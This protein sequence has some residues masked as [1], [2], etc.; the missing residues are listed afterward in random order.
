MLD[1][2]FDWRSDFNT[3]IESI[4]TH[5]KQFFKIARDIEQ[6]LQKKCIGIKDKQLL[7]II[8]DLR[9]FTGYHFYEEERLMEEIN[10]PD[11]E[12][13]KKRHNSFASKIAKISM[14]K[15]KETPEVELKKIWDIMQD[16][17]FNHILIDDMKM[18]EYILINE[19]STVIESEVKSP[20]NDEYEALYGTKICDL[21]VTK[22]YLFHEQSHKGRVV[23]VCKDKI[24]DMG[25]LS[26]LE[27]NI[28]F[29]DIARVSKAIQKLYSPQAFN[30]ASYGD[31]DSQLHFHIVPKYKDQ[32]E[33]GD[34]FSLD[35]KQKKLSQVEYE[36]MAKEI[37]KEIK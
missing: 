37:K 32:F 23:L 18:A 30:Y 6:Q 24:K 17:F 5:H 13:H 27:R 26:V 35:P 3:N 4:D 12:A 29:S 16:K 20:E 7:D 14:P 15:L 34:P 21:D 1:F 28:L 33:W 31:V 11:R 9:E 22:V 2:N 25:R 8:C 19:N 36:T 10:Y